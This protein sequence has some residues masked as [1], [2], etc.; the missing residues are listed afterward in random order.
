MLKTFVTS[1]LPHQPPLTFCFLTT[2]L[3]WERSWVIAF[4]FFYFTWARHTDWWR[5]LK[6]AKNHS[7]VPGKLFFTQRARPI[8]CKC[9][10]DYNSSREEQNFSTKTWWTSCGIQV[11]RELWCLTTVFLYK[12]L[13]LSCCH[14]LNLISC[15]YNVTKHEETQG[16]A[17]AFKCSSQCLYSNWVWVCL[18]WTV[19]NNP[20]RSPWAPKKCVSKGGWL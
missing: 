19:E 2:P 13:C 17:D 6:E 18:G 1:E 11:I 14:S 7:S 20:W 10:E 8:L 9:W 5:A 15:P 16:M 12:L 3:Q 4:H